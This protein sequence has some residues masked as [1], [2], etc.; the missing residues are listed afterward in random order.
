MIIWKLIDF[1]PKNHVTF[2]AA[3]ST[4]GGEM[5]TRGVILWKDVHS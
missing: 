5:D 2:Y 1:R 4:G 3:Y